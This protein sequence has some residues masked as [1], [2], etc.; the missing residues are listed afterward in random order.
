MD[1]L[2]S[3]VASDL[4]GRLVAFLVGK[5]QKCSTVDTA[6]RLLLRAR[7]VV[8]ETEGRQITNRAMLQQLNQLRQELCRV[9]YALDTLRWRDRRPQAVV[10]RPRPHVAPLPSGYYTD[11]PSVMVEGLEAALSGMREFVVLLGACPRVARQPYSTYLFMESCMFGR[12][13]EKEQIISFLLSQPSHQDVDVLPI[14][15]PH[16]VGK[17]TLVEHVCL[18]E[19]VR[20]R[21]AKIHRL[22]SDEL[23]IRHGDT[24]RRS[25]FDFTARLLI[26]IDVVNDDA[27][28]EE[29]WRRFHASFRRRRAHGGSK[30][31]F[32]SRTEAHAALGTVPALRLHAP[33]REELWYFF[34]T[35]AFGA[36]DPGERPDLARIAMTLCAG[37]SD[38]AVF[39]AANVVAASLRGGDQSARSWRRVLETYAGAKVL[40]LDVAGDGFG[41]G[42]AVFSY[43]CLPVTDDGAPGAPLF[44]YNRRKV[45]G[46]V[47][48]PKVTMLELLAGESLPHAGEARFDMLVWRS[49][50]PPYVSYVATCDMERARQLVAGEKRARKRWRDQHETHRRTRV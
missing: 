47:E 20:E 29:S 12:Q 25:A 36:A 30:V 34:K 48:L 24:H 32:I 21:F 8:E 10:R 17:R 14:I 6:V 16:E 18:D 33:R 43:L 50:I 40:P 27:G 22:S 13:L 26:V 11:V 45:T 4:I 31:I 9:A 44:F 46:G 5:Y 23:D 3:A 1:A 35:L 15:G 37:I 19:R 49:R 41:G 28:T 42:K 7:V 2:L 39:A 38:V